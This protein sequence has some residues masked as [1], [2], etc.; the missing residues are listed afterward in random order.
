MDT[1]NPVDT[2]PFP[3]KQSRTD[4]RVSSLAAIPSSTSHPKL[5]HQIVGRL[6]SSLPPSPK[7]EEY[8][9]DGICHTQTSSPFFRSNGRA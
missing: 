7:K 8:A 1:N 4:L 9:V 3:T 5:Y 2:A 6:S